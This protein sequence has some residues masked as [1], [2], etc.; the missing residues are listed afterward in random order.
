[1]ERRKEERWLAV[2]GECCSLVGSGTARE[3]IPWPEVGHREIAGRREGEGEDEGE[4]EGEGEGE[5][6][7][8]GETRWDEVRRRSWVESELWSASP[9]VV[10]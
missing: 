7:G 6:E 1:M 9:K 8:D 4:D 5:G 2:K 3:W 10:V